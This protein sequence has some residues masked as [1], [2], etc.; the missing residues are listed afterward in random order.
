MIHESECGGLPL[1][2]K[3]DYPQEAARSRARAAALREAAGHASLRDAQPAE[4]GAAIQAS[5]R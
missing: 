1:H 4:S 3:I 2:P 5:A